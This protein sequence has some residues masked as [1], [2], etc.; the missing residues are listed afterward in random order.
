M[1]II[2]RAIQLL[3]ERKREREKGGQTFTAAILRDKKDMNEVQYFL[4]GLV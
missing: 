4:S 3:N 1:K 2:Q